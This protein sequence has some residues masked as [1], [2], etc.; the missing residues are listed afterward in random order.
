MS[1]GWWSA[2]L[3][4]CLGC[5]HVA[6]AINEIDGPIKTPLRAVAGVMTWPIGVPVVAAAKIFRITTRSY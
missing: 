5:L 1:A 6:I 4:Y 3:L 2:L